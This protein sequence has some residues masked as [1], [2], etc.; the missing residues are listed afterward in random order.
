M[1]YLM[2]YVRPGRTSGRARVDLRVMLNLSAF[3]GLG[4]I[5]AYVEDTS[6]RRWRDEPPEPDITLRMRDCFGEISLEFAVHTAG[7]RKNSTHKIDS[8]IDALEQ[9]RVGLNAE[10]ELYASRETDQ[11]GRGP[12]RSRYL[13]LE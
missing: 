2:Q 8:L 7:L 11:T 10:A 6:R 9:F 4:A 12:E 5:R 1:S 13:D 3:H